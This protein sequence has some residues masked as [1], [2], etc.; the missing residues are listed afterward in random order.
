MIFYEYRAW[1]HATSTNDKKKVILF[2]PNRIIRVIKKLI[3]SKI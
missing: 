1:L 2:N 3:N